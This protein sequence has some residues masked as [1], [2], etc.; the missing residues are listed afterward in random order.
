MKKTIKLLFL[1]TLF[2]IT[3]LKAQNIARINIIVCIDGEIVKKLYSPRLEILDDNGHKRDI[4]FGYLPGNISIDSNDYV[5]LKSRN[6]FFLI[7]S[8]QDI[9]GGFQNYEL[10]AAK[11]WLNMDYVIVN[12]YNTDNKKYKNKL[13]PLPGK[14]YTFELEY[15]GGQMLRPR[16]K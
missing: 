12:I 14:K 16:K 3:E 5:L 7:F 1:I 11:N 10:E 6:N 15:P 9:G 2:C 13:A 4:K 8:I